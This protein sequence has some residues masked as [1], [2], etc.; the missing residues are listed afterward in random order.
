MWAQLKCP[1]RV[2]QVS[3]VEHVYC[4]AEYYPAAEHAK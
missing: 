1:L 3:K 2:E 4:I